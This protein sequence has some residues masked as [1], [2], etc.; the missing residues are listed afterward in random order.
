MNQ[1]NI[2]I[3]FISILLFFSFPL[4][5]QENI[6]KVEPNKW[7]VQLNIQHQDLL[8]N[9]DFGQLSVAHDVGFR[10]FYTAELQRFIYTK[11]PKR[12]FFAVA[13]LGY[14][15]NLYHDRWLSAKLGIGSQRKLGNFFIA[16]RVQGGLSRTKGEDIQYVLENDKWVVSKA[17]RPTT[18]DLLLSPRIDVG[19]RIT[20]TKNQIDLF[21][22]Y[23]MT[24][25]VSPVLE[26]GIPYHGYGLGVRYGF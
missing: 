26:I 12:Q 1:K 3:A 13:E 14:Y 4:I 5:G 25:Y 21:F 18:I 16:S 11:N 9:L 2:Y 19:Y 17:N 10:P 6:E 23:Q 24:L 7:A 8:V 22:N 15:N 20:E